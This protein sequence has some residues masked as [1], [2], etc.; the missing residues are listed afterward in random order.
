MPWGAI[1]GAAI[2]AL[3]SI[4]GGG[5]QANTAAQQMGMQKEFAQNGV[6]WKVADAKAAG[7]HPLAAL[8]AQ[9]FSYNPVATGDY[10]I[11]EAMGRMG[12]GI[13]RAQ[14]A[15]ALSEERAL[16]A[17]LKRAQIANVNAQT[18]AVTAQAA[19]SK[20]ALAKT[21]LPPPMPVVNQTTPNMDKPIKSYGWLKDERGKIMGI[22]PS[23]DAK[24][25]T[26]DV[27]GVEWVP[28][29]GSTARNFM[30]K[31]F[32]Q[33]VD[34]MYWH[35]QDKGFLPYPPKKKGFFN[36]ARDVVSHYSDYD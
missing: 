10:G 15:K 36:H 26:E 13:D 33:E 6:R 30:A 9:T 4:I 31:V 19:A 35:G 34:G 27:L 16:D 24:S 14:H 21:A 2:G 11:S 23:E 28:W 20:A 5:I 18:D 3:G 17:E 7:I 22:V 29:L 32:G 25:R 8:G 1:G 12:Q